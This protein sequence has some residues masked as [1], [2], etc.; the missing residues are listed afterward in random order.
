MARPLQSLRLRQ[1]IV[2][3]LRADADLTALG[4]PPLSQDDRIYGRRTPATPVWPFVRVAVADEGPLRKGTDIRLT[5]HTFSKA[6]FDD[7]CGTLNGAI[8]E[9][10]EDA[11]LELGPGTTAY[12]VWNSSQV[13]SDAAEADAWH[14]VN[15]FTATIG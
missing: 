2:T 6:Q 7:E 3:T 5:V 12:V 15:T 13:L 11:T 14:G 1:G 8:Q 4:S 9:A 10:L